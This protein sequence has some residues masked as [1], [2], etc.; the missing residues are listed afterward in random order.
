MDVL[1]CDNYPSLHQHRSGNRSYFAG[2]RMPS[3]M[4]ASYLGMFISGY[5]LILLST[6]FSVFQT[7][8]EKEFP[9]GSIAQSDVNLLLDL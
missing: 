3:G 6:S 4:K 5:A 2:R 8:N 7:P 9:W 1:F